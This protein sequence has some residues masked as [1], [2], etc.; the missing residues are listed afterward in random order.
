MILV[1]D[2]TLHRAAAYADMLHYMG[3]VARAEGYKTALAEASLCYRA[4]VIVNPTDLP[5]M[6][7]YLRRL[8]S[9]IG[10]AP[11]FAIVGNREDIPRTVGFADC[12]DDGIYSSTLMCRIADYCAKNALKVPGTYVLSGIDAS[13]DRGEVMLFDTAIPLTRTERMILRYLISVYP[14]SADAEKILKYAY[15]PSRRPE[16]SSVR[17]HICIINKKFRKIIGRSLISHKCGEGYSVI[18]PSD[19]LNTST[20]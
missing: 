13:I 20:L 7:D 6:Q 17:A 12:F 18:T 14:S 4:A 8:A 10:K 5:D 19:I 9:Y 16:E 15:R 2:K 3:V 11:I 1:I